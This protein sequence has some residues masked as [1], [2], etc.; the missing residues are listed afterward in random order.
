MLNRCFCRHTLPLL[1]ILNPD[2][3]L[4]A[5]A[6]PRG[7]TSQIQEACPGVA[8]V[9]VQHYLYHN[10]LPPEC[11]QVHIRHIQD[12]LDRIRQAKRRNDPYLAAAPGKAP[13]PAA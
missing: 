8:V 2:A 11:K 9:P 5:G 6:G 12:R 1:R 7:F 4:L 3:V 13:P 10:T